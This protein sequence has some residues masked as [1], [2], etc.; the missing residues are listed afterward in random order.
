MIS[1]RY[2]ALNNTPR[3]EYKKNW[4]SRGIRLGAY[5]KMRKYIF[6]NQNSYSRCGIFQRKANEV[7]A[8]LLL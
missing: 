5:R 6:M 2:D 8:E 7:I 1:P 3:K 4:M